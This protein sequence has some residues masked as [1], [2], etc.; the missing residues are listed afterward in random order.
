[1]MLEEVRWLGWFRPGKLEK[2]IPIAVGM[3]GNFYTRGDDR[4]VA[5][6]YESN[7]GLRG[8]TYTRQEKVY[9]RIILSTA[10]LEKYAGKIQAYL[11]EVKGFSIPSH[12]KIRTS[13]EVLDLSQKTHYEHKWAF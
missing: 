12:I 10:E 6:A 11:E 8:G 1:M 4:W 7:D 2:E 3:D 9:R 13:G 5:G